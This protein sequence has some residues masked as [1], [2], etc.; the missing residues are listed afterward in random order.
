MNKI[1]LSILFVFSVAISFGQNAKSP[2]MTAETKNVKVTYGQPSKKGRVIFGDLVPYGEVWRTGANE[3][4]EITFSSDV[5]ISGKTI[6]AGTYTLFT[7]PQKNTWTI[8]LNSELKQWGSYG[9]S[10][11]KDKNVLS[12]EVNVE[13]IKEQEKLSFSF[14]DNSKGTTLNMMWD[15]VKVSLPIQF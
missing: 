2:K 5:V 3:A 15:S 10:K 8:I 4:T 1:Y 14:T 7:I 9:Y 6:K 11:I 13:T 12:V